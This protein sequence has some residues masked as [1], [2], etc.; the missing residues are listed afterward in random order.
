MTITSIQIIVTDDKGGEY[1]VQ[2]DKHQA[3]ILIN[4]LTTVYHDGVIKVT[5]IN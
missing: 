1:V 3:S 2:L 4:D 5:H